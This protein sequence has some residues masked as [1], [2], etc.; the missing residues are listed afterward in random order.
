MNTGGKPVISKNGLLTTIGYSLGDGKTAYALEGSVAIAGSLVQW[1]RDKLGIITSSREIDILASSV[2]DNGGI[3]YVPA[4][5]GL[6]APRWR[7]DARGVIAGLTHY[8]GKA[9]FA[10]AILEATAYQTRD[11]FDAMADDSLIS[12]KELKVDGGM[13]VSDVLMQFQS[14]ILNVKVLRPTVTESTGRGAAYAAGLAVGF[15]DGLDDLRKNWIL[16]REWSPVMDEKSRQGFYSSW[17][18]AVERS[19][20]WAE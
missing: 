11:V 8:A 1:A 4:F 3:Y 5:S 6:F 2:P 12:L 13:T 16:D 20:G 9:H 19:L 7:S 18:K 10:R 15:W 17:L 14:D